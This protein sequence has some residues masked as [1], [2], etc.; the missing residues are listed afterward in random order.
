MSSEDN[1]FVLPDV[2]G[3][4]DSASDSANN[5]SG[6]A[7]PPPFPSE[8]PRARRSRTIPPQPVC[9]GCARQ[10]EPR[11]FVPFLKKSLTVA[12]VLPLAILLFL[13]VSTILFSGLALVSTSGSGTDID[14]SNV[15]E[16]VLSGDDTLPHK[17]A[18]LPIEG[19][20]TENEEGFIRQAIRTAYQD[21]DI[22]ALVL[23]VNSP[24]GTIAGADYYYTL[25]KQLKD[26]RSIPVI[27][28]MGP[29]A[30]SG[31]YYVSMVGDKIFAE[32]STTTGS[33]GVIC[34]IPNASG[35]CEKIGVTMNNITSGPHKAMGDFSQ[36]MA[37]DERAIWQELVN[38]SYRQFLAVIRDGRPN[39]RD[40][41]ENSADDTAASDEAATS[42]EAAAD[43][44]E[45]QTASSSPEAKPSEKPLEEIADGR[46]YTALQALELGLID[47]IGFLDDAIKAAGV[48]AGIS[49][50]E[51][52]VVRYAK[53]DGF[54]ATLLAEQEVRFSPRFSTKAEAL[55]EALATPT[56][57][58][59]MPGAL[60]LD[61]ES[62]R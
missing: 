13:L 47:E 58:C 27:V 42:D 40:P 56:I 24:G 8:P 38:D 36:P 4:D 30:A 49:P 44:E 57:Y 60:P 16:K 51:T 46:V 37:D 20:I 53:T 11:I 54:F 10:R 48:A 18:V 41:A 29:V 39:L 34:E 32:R 62:A 45:E 1:P 9:G 59:L 19:I 43:G 3:V 14:N 25:L 52:Q 50:D 2:N 7:V 55:V 21:K 22:D 23:R 15:T 33:I 26:E 6:A 5:P 12:L 61:T 17:I 28:S 31:G 35:L